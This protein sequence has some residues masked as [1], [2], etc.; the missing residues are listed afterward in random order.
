M[1]GGLTAFITAR[2][3]EDEAIARSAAEQGAAEW[4]ASY[5]PE[6]EIRRESCGVYAGEG[7]MIYDEG[8]PSVQEALHVARH[9]PARALA[10]VAAK[11]MIA[12]L[13]DRAHDCP[14]I[15][16]VS[17]PGAFPGALGY[18]STE[19]IDGEDPDPHVTPCT[20][21]RALAAVYGGHPDYREEWR[22]L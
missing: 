17:N 15:V 16:P 5:D 3:D 7:V 18:V 22:P 13:H 2:F 19:H 11:R 14:V 10:E 9:D 6:W 4:T 20:T 21:L 8:T 1:T 12:E